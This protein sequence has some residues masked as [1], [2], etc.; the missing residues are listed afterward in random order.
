[1]KMMKVKRLLFIPSY[2]Y[3]HVSEVMVNMN[4]L[5]HQSIKKYPWLHLEA[6]EMDCQNI[7][8]P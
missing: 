6:E 2:S 5:Q 3:E 1:M 8:H 4:D 7:T